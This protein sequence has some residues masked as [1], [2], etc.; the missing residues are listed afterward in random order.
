MRD[1]FDNLYDLQNV[2]AT[3]LADAGQSLLAIKELTRCQSLEA[4]MPAWKWQRY[5]RAL[6]DAASATLVALNCLIGNDTPTTDALLREIIS[7]WQKTTNP[8]DREKIVDVL[9]Q[10]FAKKSTEGKQ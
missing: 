5:N 2:I 8:A 4:L 1:E 9:R 3:D 6:S 7:R 10:A